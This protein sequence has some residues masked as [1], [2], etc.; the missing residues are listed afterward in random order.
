MTDV[1]K[2]KLVYAKDQLAK[3]A[4][5]LEELD[6]A[7]IGHSDCGRLVYSYDG[8]LSHFKK[9]GM[10]SGDAMEW[11]GFNV[12]PLTGQGAGFVLCY[13]SNYAETIDTSEQPVDPI[14]TEK[15]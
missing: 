14:D 9:D 3:G 8:I 11:V 10:N 4:V 13:E 5:I 6:S 2:M 1:E 15:N 12:L 7:I